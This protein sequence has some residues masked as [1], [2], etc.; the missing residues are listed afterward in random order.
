MRLFVA[1]SL[2]EDVRERLTALGNGLP[3]AR[4][5]AAEN[6]HLTL[7][8]VGEVDNA[9]AHDLDDMLSAIDAPSFELTLQGLATFGDGARLRVLY[10]AVAPSPALLHLQAK[11]ESAVMRAGLPI[12][13]R[14]FK[15]HVALARFKGDP[16]PKLGRYLEERSLLRVGP[17]PIESFVLY[18]SLLGAEG[19]HYTEEVVYDLDPLHVA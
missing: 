13:R 4:W 14:K 11:V 8:F 12:E 5:V 18:S 19:P 16:G 10:A 15:P 1:L 9:A 17:F 3:G 7:R 6:L 2:P